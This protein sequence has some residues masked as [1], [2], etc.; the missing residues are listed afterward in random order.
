MGIT[1]G[2]TFISDSTQIQF[3]VKEKEWGR[4]KGKEKAE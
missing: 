3:N 2:W 1:W 4:W